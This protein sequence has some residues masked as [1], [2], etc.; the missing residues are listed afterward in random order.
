LGNHR[1]VIN[2][3]GQKGKRRDGKN[4]SQ[5]QKKKM[6]RRV[7]RNYF[8]DDGEIL[9]FVILQWDEG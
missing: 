8:F 7:K 6:Y 1:K 4:I 9:N 5:R 2:Q 3:I